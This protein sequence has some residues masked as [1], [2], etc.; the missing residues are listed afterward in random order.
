MSSLMF[1]IMMISAVMP[2]GPPTVLAAAG[3]PI[4]ATFDQRVPF[5]GF[6]A[7]TG[8]VDVLTL[9]AVSEAEP[10]VLRTR[11]QG[12][13]LRMNHGRLLVLRCFLCFPYY[14][15]VMKRARF[16]VDW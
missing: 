4:V 6:A 5:I 9:M 1:I 13:Q 3:T 7:A 10:L 12:G 2:Y 11:G 16:R 8:E 15:R 14:F